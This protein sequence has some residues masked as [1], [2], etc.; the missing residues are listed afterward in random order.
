MWYS[1]VVRI[2]CNSSGDGFVGSTKR[3]TKSPAAFTLARA[4][5]RYHLPRKG[6]GRVANKVDLPTF[7]AIQPPTMGR[8]SSLG[9][10]WRRTHK[11]SPGERAQGIHAAHDA[12]AQ[13]SRTCGTRLCH[14]KLDF[15][16]A[17]SAVRSVTTSIIEAFEKSN[18]WQGRLEP[19]ATARWAV[20]LLGDAARSVQNCTLSGLE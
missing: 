1:M 15:G 9:E 20:E 19:R 4:L 10:T 6:V 7:D 12:V 18:F 5:G 13:P 8:T 11:R 16:G 3:G 17:V 2:A 14:R